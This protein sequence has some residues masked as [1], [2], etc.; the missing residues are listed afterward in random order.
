MNEG[1]AEG[2]DVVIFG[3]T[4][5]VMISAV[6]IEATKSGRVSN[7]AIVMDI[8]RQRNLIEG[9]FTRMYSGSKNV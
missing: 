5:H 8:T 6:Y 7:L 3:N 2:A 4:A 1:V 9:S